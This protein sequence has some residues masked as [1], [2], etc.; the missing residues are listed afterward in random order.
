MRGPVATTSG[1]RCYKGHRSAAGSRFCES[2]G[3]CGGGKPEVGAADLP[4]PTW[5]G[6]YN[7]HAVNEF[8]MA[9]ARGARRRRAPPTRLR[10]LRRRFSWVRDAAMGPPPRSP[11]FPPPA[12]WVPAAASCPAAKGRDRDHG[13]DSRARSSRPPAAGVLEGLFAEQQS[14]G[15]A[16]SRRVR[17]SAEAPHRAAAGAANRVASVPRTRRPSIALG[18]SAPTVPP[19]PPHCPWPP[20]PAGS[21]APA[22]ITPTRDGLRSPASSHDAP[23]SQLCPNSEKQLPRPSSSG[24]GGG[25]LGGR[26]DSTGLPAGEHDSG[27]RGWQPKQFGGAL[28][29]PCRVAR[30]PLGWFAQPR[31]V[32]WRSAKQWPTRGG[33]Q[34]LSLSKPW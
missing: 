3:R 27:Q 4:P 32:G 5:S 23:T 7:Q 11:G 12:S 26:R 29:R 33:Y 25:G 17:R 34:R 1:P 20:S 31:W 2:A 8:I 16:G 22:H 10:R 28:D 9:D 24:G 30:A 21:C 15:T 14:K 13:P 19:S 18:S 6:D